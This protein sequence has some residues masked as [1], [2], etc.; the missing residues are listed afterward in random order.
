MFVPN[1]L[2]LLTL[3][4]HSLRQES[5][6]T[7]SHRFR[8]GSLLVA[9]WM[10]MSA[11]YYSWFMGSVGQ[12]FVR[13]LTYLDL[14][15][16]LVAGSSYFGAVITEE[17]EQ[18]TLGL[19]KLAG[20][21]NAG[22]MFGKSSA[23]IVIA[24]LIFLIQL[25]FA[26]LAIVLGGTTVT[27]IIAAYLSLAAFLILLGNVGL[28]LSVV[29][30]RNSSATTLTFVVGALALWSGRLAGF[31]LT[32]GPSTKVPFVR[33]ALS[34]V[35]EFG[36]WFSPEV[37]LSETML[38][39]STP[40]VTGQFWASLAI[41]AGLF[42]LSW[43]LFDRFTEYTEAHDPHRSRAG[44]RPQRWQLWVT[45]PRG[46][47]MAWKEF[48]F[49]GGGFTT[50]IGKSLLYVAL[51][52]AAKLC[53]ARFQAH[54]GSSLTEIVH[55]SL[56]AILLLEV[57]AFSGS[58]LGGEFKEGT[59]P[60]LILT[61]NSFG[62]IVASKFLGGLVVISPTLVACVVGAFILK[63]HDA[64]LFD[65]HPRTL[66]L[67]THFVL[68][69]HLT[70]FY[71]IRVRRGAIA[72]A[73]A[74]LVLAGVFVLPLLEMVRISLLGKDARNLTTM[75]YS[76]GPEFWAPLLYASILACIA[77][78]IAIGVQVRRAVGE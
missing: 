21:S 17:K 20:F 77:T 38:S 71:S 41:A 11:H 12:A 6:S 10:L 78:Q 31:S 42:G 36:Q 44:L 46:N 22:L 24:M 33:S 53:E 3:L 72:W 14:M 56:F 35:N 57:L 63:G 54:Y 59:L 4:S 39:R 32:A 28:I 8:I 9:T 69:L 43:L 1:V 61:P 19:L 65:G 48:H 37:R 70:T 58:F 66:V 16:I 7:T 52:V 75:R 5:R 26:F 45:R 23:R 64:L 55:A 76:E 29:C 68:L 62:R 50:L 47:A 15:L 18:G 51:I 40:L 67:V 27:Q 49:A 74:T 2:N 25:P 13:S 60:N 73:L 34:G 30:R